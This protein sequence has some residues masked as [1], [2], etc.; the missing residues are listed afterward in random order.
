[1]RNNLIAV[2]AHPPRQVNLM[3]QLHLQLRMKQAFPGGSKSRVNLAGEH[4]RSDALSD[5]DAKVLE[6]WRSAHRAVL[7]T[8]QALLRKRTRGKKIT[9]AH[10]HKRRST[11]INKL[12][13]EPKMQLVRM[14]DIAG[15]RV[16][17]ANEAALHAFRADFHNAR[18]NHRRLNDVDKYNYIIKPK[19]SGYRGIHDV[20]AYDVNSPS[21]K[22]LDG[23][24]IE[25]QYRT[26]VQ[27][28]WATAVELVGRITENQP[29]FGAGDEKYKRVM[30]LAS[31]IIARTAENHRGPFPD[32]QDRVVVEEFAD[33]DN[34]LGLM[35]KFSGLQATGNS[36][37]KV[38]KSNKHTLL[39]FPPF[40]KLQVRAFT[41]EKQAL[42]ELFDM[43]R[44]TPE[45]DVVLVRANSAAEVRLAFRNYFSDAQDFIR[46]IGAGCK[47]LVGI[48]GIT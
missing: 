47:E 24:L 40:D 26:L 15:C 16:I 22:P 1:V 12:A 9:V 7:N 31:E 32:L 21:G 36:L 42:K 20:Y 30:A 3:D 13:R 14:D 38:I 11:I 29:K 34:E 23:L 37:D 19:P 25:V 10:R 4:I 46:L 44:E 43:E 39:I 8:F 2:A 28:A 5:D 27:H 17:F 18:F 41:D 33:L 45:N 6:E 35:N 48:S